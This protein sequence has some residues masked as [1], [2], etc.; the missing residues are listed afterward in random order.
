MPERKR[1]KKGASGV[2]AS[3]VATVTAAGVLVGGA[4]SSP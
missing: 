4:Y 3:A 2:A 1:K